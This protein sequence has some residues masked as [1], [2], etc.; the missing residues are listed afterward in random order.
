MYTNSA[1]V[2]G[3]DA[4]CAEMLQEL[5]PPAQCLFLRLYQRRG[6]WF[7]Q[8]AFEYPEVGEAAPAVQQLS[9]S[10]FLAAATEADNAE[11]VQVINSNCNH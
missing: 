6:P 9:D 3:R 4:A 8:A 11:L 5:P 7:R 1:F 10:G 2:A